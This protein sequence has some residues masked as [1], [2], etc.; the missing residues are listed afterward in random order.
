VFAALTASAQ[1]QFEIGTSPNP[2][3]SGARAMGVGNAFV[4][5]ADDATAASWNPG[6]LAQ[7]E[8]PEFS[9]AVDG[10][11]RREWA[12]SRTIGE[13]DGDHTVD[14]ANVNYASLVL[15][16]YVRRP[17]VFSLSYL[18][19]YNFDRELDLDFAVDLGIAQF[20]GSLRLTQAGDFS[21]VTP[22]YAVDLT[23]R[24]S[25]GFALNIWDHAVT[26]SSEYYKR[27][28]QDVTLT[29]VG[30]DPVPQWQHRRERFR[31]EQG[32]SIVLGGLYRF[33]P[34]WNVG[35]VI[36]P[37]FALELDHAV[38]DAKFNGV[39]AS[40]VSTDSAARLHMPTIIGAGIAWRPSDRCV[41]TSDLTWT[42]WS[43]YRLEENGAD[44]SPISGVTHADSDVRDTVTA[45]LGAERYFFSERRI[46]TLR[47]GVGYDPAPAEGGVD[48]FYTVNIG[49]GL[50]VRA[51]NIDVAYEL[52][53]GNEVGGSTLLGFAA[54]E[55]VWQHRV[56]ASV[57]KYF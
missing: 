46:W 40:T 27:E 44:T 48:D 24:L 51:I 49:V 42:Q 11:Y 20:D 32:R 17:M 5:L 29:G 36:K 50:Q 38:V 56:L 19:Q 28:I 25:L 23:D 47:G 9:L 13:V 2:V 3:G 30:P 53:Y 12:N 10:V 4:A 34:E 54:D 52:R 33:S 43:R 8:L 45:R 6:G 16:F 18:K 41:V 21:V 15:P 7:L 22:A 39:N 31:V 26:G 35:V 55:D 1:L 57:I 37:P 14:F